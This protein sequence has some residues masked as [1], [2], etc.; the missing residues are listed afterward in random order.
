MKS[1]ICKRSISILLCL[2]LVISCMIISL[3][4]TSAAVLPDGYEHDFEREGKTYENMGI[5]EDQ[6][7][8]IE[9]AN[10]RYPVISPSSLY[11]CSYPPFF[12]GT[13]EQVENEF[14]SRGMTDGMPIVPPTKIKAEKFM[15]YSSYGYD[16]VIATVNNKSVKAYM[17]AANAIMAGCS[18]EHLPVCIAFTQALSDN[19]YLDSLRSGKLTPMMY[20]NG[21]MARQ[22]GIDC[23]QGMT[24]EEANISIGRFMELALINLAGIK[25]TNA[26]GN[27]QPL[28]FSEN[29]EVCENIGWKPHHVEQGYELNDNVITATSFSMWGNNVTPA[30]DLPDEIMKVLAWDVTEKNLGGL[31]SASIEDNAKA[32]R[33]I[34]I[35][36]SVATALSTKYKSKEALEGALVENARRPLWMRTYAYYYANT[37]DALKKSF[38]DV[39]NELKSAKSEDAKSTASPPWMNGITYAN[40]DTVATMTKGNTNIIITGDS[41]RNKT[42]VM[43][44]GISVSE[45]I[46]LSNKWDALVTSVNYNPIEMFYLT[47][48]DHTI[49]PP[50]SVPSVLVNGSYRII[51]PATLDAGLTTKGTLYFDKSTNTLHY[52]LNSGSAEATTVIDPESNAS[53]IAYL[54]N[55][56][57]NSSFTVSNHKISAVTIRLSSNAKKLTTNTT[58]LTND[59]FS[60]M[61]LTIHANNKNSYAAGGLAKDGATVTMSDT[62][63]SFTA[64]FNG[65]IVMGESTNAKFVKLSGTT[66]TVDPTVEAGATAVIGSAN[67]DGTYRTMTFNN[68]GD[69]TYTITYNT[70]NSLTN[71]VSAYCLKGTFNNWEA[72]DTFAKT[73]NSDIISITKELPKGTYEFKIYKLGADEWYG[74]STATT[75]TDSVYR[76]S[77]NKSSDSSNVTLVASGGKY[78]FKYEI[79]TKK[80]SVYYSENK[81]MDEQ[82]TVPTSKEKYV[83]GDANLS[84]SIEIIDV[85]RIQRYL[86]HIDNLSQEAILCS[87][88][89]ANGD[90]N[91][92][93]CTQIQRFLAKLSCS[94][95]VGKEFTI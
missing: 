54:D 5:L 80:L 6:Y 3:T 88:A 43:P 42:Q 35:T 50:T 34:F 16:E 91:I 67:T 66:V 13:Y 26:F 27:V 12:T 41:S 19:D 53:F 44:G 76:T 10:N 68:S 48:Q 65:D 15:A 24:T 32:K 4:A 78:E 85:T 64:D 14:Q 79:S 74:C 92:I 23:T 57:Y 60:G 40:I 62:V 36:E 28:V 51:D 47:E 8:L 9:P 55:L 25:R 29:E 93:D 63:T 2:L 30:T 77:L 17:V 58:A 33:L 72:N 31:G 7:D 20:V 38:S 22:I 89:N 59:S 1:N 69:G 45:E 46:K 86:A 56:G 21:P 84:G 37:G 18:P 87:D 39:Y 75:I 52:Y 49:T 95:N 73:D 82:P 94:E 81:A 70:A 71:D 61:N 83:H 11:D 90:V